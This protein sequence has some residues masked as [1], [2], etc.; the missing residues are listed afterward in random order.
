MTATR[1]QNLCVYVQQGQSTP[2]RIDERTK[3]FRAVQHIV[4]RA[5]LLLES[6]KGW[7]AFNELA[8]KLIIERYKADQIC[9]YPRNDTDRFSQLSGRLVQFLTNMRNRFPP[10]LL[11]LVEGEAA[12][13]RMQWG[14]VNSTLDDYDT[15]GA[16]DLSIHRGVSLVFLK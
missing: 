3:D 7:T 13:N 4:D 2:Q 10:V 6:G 11:T 5:L 15:E 12:C 9:L 14:N 8:K 1:L 16:G